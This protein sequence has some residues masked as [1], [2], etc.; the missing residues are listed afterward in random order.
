MKLPAGGRHYPQQTWK[1][2]D[3]FNGGRTGRLDGAR[4]AA[5]GGVG[6]TLT[7]VPPVMP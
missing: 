3:G 2:W 6:M 1:G 5:F 4:G 7:Y